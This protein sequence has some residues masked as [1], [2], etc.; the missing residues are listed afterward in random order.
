MLQILLNA[1]SLNFTIMGSSE[2]Q[3]LILS[4]G[5]Q[6]VSSCSRLEIMCQLGFWEYVVDVFVKWLPWWAWW[7]TKQLPYLPKEYRS[8]PTVFACCTESSWAGGHIF[9]QSTEAQLSRM[10]LEPIGIQ[11]FIHK[12]NEIDVL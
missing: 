9:K 10:P 5:P 12:Q 4:Q 3:N 8:F 7:V 6:V 11:A 1:T 2:G